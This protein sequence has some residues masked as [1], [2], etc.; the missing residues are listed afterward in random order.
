MILSD[1]I[2]QPR[3]DAV[4]YSRYATTSSGRIVVRHHQAV[5][6][7]SRAMADAWI[8]A[9]DPAALATV[10]RRAWVRITG[11]T[12]SAPQTDPRNTSSRTSGKSTITYSR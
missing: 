2:P 10:K 3:P 11:R 12:V 8:I 6:A 7:L 1:V 9:P 5:H 4:N